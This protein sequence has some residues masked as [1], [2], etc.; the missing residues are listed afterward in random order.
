[1]KSFQS[2]YSLIF[3]FILK[4]LLK[5]GKLYSKLFLLH[6]KWWRNKSWDCVFI[7][8]CSNYSI[9]FLK[10]NFNLTEL[11][12]TIDLRSFKE[13]TYLAI[14]W[15]SPIF[16]LMHPVTNLTF[17]QSLQSKCSLQSAPLFCCWWVEWE[18]D[19]SM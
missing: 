3:I 9:T 15:Q 7:G 13:K 2:A 8:F 19:Q 18:I 4:V 14:K 16:Y 12:E 5:M 6:S 17:S 10:H 11:S 1:M